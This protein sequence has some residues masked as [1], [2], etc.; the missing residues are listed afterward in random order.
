MKRPLI[1]LRPIRAIREA[2]PISETQ[3][4]ARQLWAQADGAMDLLGAGVTKV[5]RRRVLEPL[6]Y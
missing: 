2:V 4:C 5:Q 3:I 1:P 6:D